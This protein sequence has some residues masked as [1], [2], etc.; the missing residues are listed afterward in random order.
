[1]AALIAPIVNSYDRLKPATMSGYWCNW[2]GDQRSVTTRVSA[3]GGARHALNTA[4]VMVLPILMC[5]WRLY[6][7]QL[8]LVLKIAMRCPHAKR[9]YCFE[10]STAT[11]ATPDNLSEALDELEKDKVLREE[12]GAVLAQNLIFMKR[13]EVEKTAKLE[14]NALRDFYINYV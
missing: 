13:A 3:E 10:H 11:S 8:G 12:V 6:Y 14:G 7:K 5:W 2:G 9:E 1:M 4:W